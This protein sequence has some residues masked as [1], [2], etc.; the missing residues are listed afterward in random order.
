MLTPS[1]RAAKASR[2]YSD[3]AMKKTKLFACIVLASAALLGDPAGLTVSCGDGTGQSGNCAVGRVTFASSAY[4]GTVHVSVVRD[5]T[6]EVY[7]NFDYD[8]SGGSIRFTQSL[9]P[10]GSYTVTLVSNGVNYTQTVTTGY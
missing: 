10:G 3:L 7:D 6:G 5:S 4:S 9:I 8:A 1:G 2:V